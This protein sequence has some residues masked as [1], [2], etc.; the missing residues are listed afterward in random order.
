[1]GASPAEVTGSPLICSVGRLDRLKGHQRVIAAMPALLELEPDAHLAV[2]GRGSF[3]FELR[4]LAARLQVDHAVT[5]TSFDATQR[6]ARC[7]RPIQRCRRSDERFRG[8]PR[9]R[10][11]GCRPRAKGGC[12]RHFWTVGAGGQGSRRRRAGRRPTAR[13][14]RG[15]G[16][17][18]G[19]S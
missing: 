11:G 6:S 16:R 9:R 5:F 17:C 12:G 14:G 3:E 19:P 8:T 4:R 1:V 18:C 13:P 2:I 15:V 10:Y 7:A